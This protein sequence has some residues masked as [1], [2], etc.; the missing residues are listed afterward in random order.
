MFIKENVSK[1]NTKSG[2]TEIKT[3]VVETLHDSLKRE[4]HGSI[5]RKTTMQ[6]YAKRKLRI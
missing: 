6:D 5:F 2:L 4:G 1:D 3:S